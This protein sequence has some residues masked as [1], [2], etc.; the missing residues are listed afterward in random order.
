MQTGALLHRLAQ[1]CRIDALTGTWELHE[2]L[3]RSSIRGHHHSQSA[4]AFPSD[5][6]HLN[7]SVTR[8][9]DDDRRQAAFD[10]IDIVYQ[11]IAT[12]KL[13]ADGKLDRRQMRCQQ[14]HVVGR[15]ARQ[16]AI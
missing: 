2:G 10:E 9:V 6:A 13:E 4:H 15:E 14:T 8:A 5:E 16:N 1:A 7:T 11:P 3:V 12:L